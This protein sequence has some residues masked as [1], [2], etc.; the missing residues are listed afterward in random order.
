MEF[1]SMEKYE[2]MGDMWEEYQA[3]LEAHPES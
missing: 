1:Y 3:W 2:I